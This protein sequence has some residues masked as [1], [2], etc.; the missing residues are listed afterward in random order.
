MS[1]DYQLKWTDFGDAISPAP[2][3]SICDA[4]GQYGLRRNN[5]GISLHDTYEAAVGAAQ[6]DF[7]LYTGRVAGVQPMETAPKDGT[8][9]KLLIDYSAA[10]LDACPLEDSAEPGWTLG[11]NNFE[12]TEVDEWSW[13]GWDWS[14]DCIRETRAGKPI[15]WAPFS[16]DLV[17]TSSAADSK[18]VERLRSVI[19]EFP[20]HDFATDA[21]YLREIDQWW[22]KS[23][24]PA[25]A[26]QTPARLRGETPFHERSENGNKLPVS[27]KVFPADLID[28]LKALCSPAAE[29]MPDSER[30][31]QL[32]RAGQ[33]MSAALAADF[34]QALPDGKLDDS[35]YEKIEEVLDQLDAPCRDENGEWLS[36]YE[37]MDQ[38]REK[39]VEIASETA[40]N[41][42]TRC[43]R[44]MAALGLDF[45]DPAEHLPDSISDEMIDAAIDAYSPD[46]IG[47]QRFMKVE[48]AAREAMRASVEAALR[49]GRDQKFPLKP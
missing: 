16:V 8:W 12:N 5:E 20:A 11:S 34:T 1:F 41:W 23:A 46:Y 7:D 44:I 26:S 29:A 22:I 24:M 4:N 27:G 2:K 40:P 30:L 31:T 42:E 39:I 17:P 49:V 45:G 21:E 14:H 38:L 37:R 33:E 18:Y 10:G 19:K 32:V 48:R 6:T 36:L 47:A 25:L 35:T 15:G 43:R 28:K 9:I 3:Y 13:M